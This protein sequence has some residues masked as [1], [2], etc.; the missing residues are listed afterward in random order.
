MG[1][2]YLTADIAQRTIAIA[3]S[4]IISVFRINQAQIPRCIPFVTFL[5]NSPLRHAHAQTVM[6]AD[7]Q[8]KF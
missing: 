6:P 7:A 5:M 4:I 2:I 3:G 8:M 1:K